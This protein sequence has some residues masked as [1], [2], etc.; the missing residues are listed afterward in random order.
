MH[1]TYLSSVKAL[2]L[3]LPELYQ[4]GFQVTT[5]SQLANLKNTNLN[6]N[7]IYYYFK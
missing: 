2:E 4:E 5:V 7:E 1:E 6:N 3:I